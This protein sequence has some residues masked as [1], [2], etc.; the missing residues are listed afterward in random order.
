MYN[1]LNNESDGDLQ[2]IKKPA[3]VLFVK[4][5]YDHREL[6]TRLDDSVKD[7]RNVRGAGIE[8]EKN[9]GFLKTKID[10]GKVDRNARGLI[11]RREYK[12]GF[13]IIYK[14]NDAGRVIYQESADGKCHVLEYNEQGKLSKI[15]KTHKK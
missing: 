8:P 12:N 1:T 6:V 5:A 10:W 13:W 11:T 9:G 4:T 3:P 7:L 14:Y 15:I 2:E